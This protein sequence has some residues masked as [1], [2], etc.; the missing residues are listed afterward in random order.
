MPKQPKPLTGLRY[1]GRGAFLP[2]IPA[3]D[4]SVEEIADRATILRLV[5]EALQDYLLTSGLY[6]VADRGDPA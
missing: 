6:E 5:P 1:I 2:D 4:L 3:R